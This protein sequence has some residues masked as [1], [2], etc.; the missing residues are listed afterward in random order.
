MRLGLV[1]ALCLAI[2]GG[3][4]LFMGRTPDDRV[5]AAPP[6]E[7]SP[8]E[9][10]APQRQRV[11]ATR[12]PRVTSKPAEKALRRFVGEHFSIRYPSGW[13]IETA[14]LSKGPYLDTTIRSPDSPSTYLRVDVTPERGT[15]PAVHAA[16]VEA[17]LKVQEGYSRRSLERT[18]HGRLPAVRWEFD[19]VEAGLGLRKV[20]VFLTDADGDR[21]AVL[22]QAPASEFA[23]HAR[24]FDLLRTSLVPRA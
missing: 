20:D 2:F 8:A 17:Y 15:D 14:E 18:K 5:V 12:S 6:R 7:A 23:R 4:Y 13:R 11:L 9:P 24:L 1:A 21:I 22:T 10:K 16:E 19:V 3:V